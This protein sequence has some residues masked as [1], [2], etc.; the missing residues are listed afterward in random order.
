MSLVRSELFHIIQTSAELNIFS[1]SESEKKLEIFSLVFAHSRHHS[2]VYA[3]H[4]HY[5]QTPV[6][7]HELRTKNL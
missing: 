1:L 6:Y 5:I 7:K 3:M 4:I 2:W